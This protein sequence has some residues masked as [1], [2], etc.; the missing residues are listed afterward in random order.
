MFISDV[1]IVSAL[2]DVGNIQFIMTKKDKY[3]FH[4]YKHYILKLL[5]SQM[6][7]ECTMNYIIDNDV[8]INILNKFSYIIRNSEIENAWNNGANPDDVVVQLAGDISK[9]VMKQIFVNFK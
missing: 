4:V 1:E 6:H 8:V 7:Q 9:S 5:M 2:N 3:N